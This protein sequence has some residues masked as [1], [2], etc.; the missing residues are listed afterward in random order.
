MGDV[1]YNF[2][3]EKGDIVAHEVN[4]R[5]ISANLTRLRKTPE[6]VLTSGG[7]EKISAIRGVIVTL[8]PTVFI[9][10]EVTARGLIG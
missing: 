1:L 7:R 6:R 9:T 10:D 4:D 5:V 2:I 3:D 8:G